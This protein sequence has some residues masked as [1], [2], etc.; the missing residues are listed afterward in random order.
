M[1]DIKKYRKKNKRTQEGV[2]ERKKKNGRFCH[3]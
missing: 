1:K 3:Y 2:D